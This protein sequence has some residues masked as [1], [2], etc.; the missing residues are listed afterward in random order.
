MVGPGVGGD[1]DR[2]DR[3]FAR[4]APPAVARQLAQ[5]RRGRAVHRHHHVVERVVEVAVG[6][7]PAGIVVDMAAR[8]PAVRRDVDTAAERQGVVDHHQFLVVA[9]A[10]RVLAIDAEGDA[11]VR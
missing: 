9:G 4:A 2:R 3:R 5:R 6:P 11:R 8:V 7:P 10:G 1:G